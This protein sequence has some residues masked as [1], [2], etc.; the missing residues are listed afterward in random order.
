MLFVRPTRGHGGPYRVKAV[1]TQ[2]RSIMQT[3]DQISK[4]I[5]LVWTVQETSILSP[6]PTFEVWREPSKL[7]NFSER[8]IYRENSNDFPTYLYV[9][10]IFYNS[11][12]VFFVFFSV[13]TLVYFEERMKK[14]V[15]FITFIYHSILLY[16]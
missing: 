4:I 16:F 12:L 8:N 1:I 14:M 5:I 10:Q 9:L 2:R 3:R 15:H 11:V 7:S 13:T 6:M